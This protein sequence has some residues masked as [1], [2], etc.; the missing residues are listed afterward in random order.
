[1]YFISGLMMNL[2]AT[3]NDT[4]TDKEYLSFGIGHTSLLEDAY[5]LV[6]DHEKK[7]HSIFNYIVIEEY[8][9]GYCPNVKNKIYFDWDEYHSCWK[10]TH[11]FP[12]DKKDTQWSF[13]N[14]I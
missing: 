14:N 10:E 6:T 5:K 4:F 9:Q 1:M 3:N 12:D 2:S 13:L 8:G 7:L 11:N